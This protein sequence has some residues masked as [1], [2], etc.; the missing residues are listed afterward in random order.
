MSRAVEHLAYLVATVLF[1]FSLHWM[2]TPKTARRGVMAGVAGMTLAILATWIQPQIVHHGWIVIAMIAGGLAGIPLA[3]VSL[4][5]VPQR[6]ALSHAFGG[7]AAGLVGAAKFYLWTYHESRT[8][9]LLSH[10]RHRGRGH[11]RISDAHRQPDGRGQIARSLLDPATA[12]D[13][14]VSESRPTWA[15]LVLAALLGLSLVLYPTRRGWAAFAFPVMCLLA[16][17]FGVL[18]IIPIGGADMPTVIS[19]LER[20][21]RPLRRRD[22]IRAR[23]QTADHGGRP[24]RRQ[25]LYP[26]DHHVPGHEPFIHERAVRRVRPGA[27]SRSGGRTAALQEPKRSKTRPSSSNNRRWWSSFPATAWPSRR[28]STASASCT[29]N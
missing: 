15:C 21:R 24:R 14:S 18:L 8:A 7:L 23:Q 2:N 6:T 17:A 16:L 25:R 19:I 26:V 28:P 3:M 27:D 22:G 10:V 29:M 1:I 12:G 11:P 20:V 5:A 9:D 4:T 13:L